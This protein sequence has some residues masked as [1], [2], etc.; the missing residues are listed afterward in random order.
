MVGWLTANRGWPAL[1]A[2]IVGYEIACAEGELLSEGF[3]RLL[4]R[5]PVWPRLA[6]FAVALHL[7]NWLPGWADPIHLVFHKTR[8]RGAIIK[9]MSAWL[10]QRLS[11]G[12]ANLNRM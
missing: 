3:D 2:A 7:V 5:H 1:V 9:G 6:V 11:F 4:E 8:R 10:A 12:I